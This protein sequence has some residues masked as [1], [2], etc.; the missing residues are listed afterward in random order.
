MNAK[1]VSK[2][3]EGI[4]YFI[5]EFNMENAHFRKTAISII[6]NEAKSLKHH[7]FLYSKSEPA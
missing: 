2:H 3:S 7:K 5:I 6:Q 1:L 4:Y